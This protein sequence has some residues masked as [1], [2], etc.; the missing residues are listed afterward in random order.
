M[1]TTLKRVWKWN[2]CQDGWKK[3]L[4]SL[5]KTEP[6]DEPISIEHII[7][8][9]GIRDAIWALR[10]TEGHDREIRLYAVW[11]ERHLMED[12]RSI[13]AL[14]VA[15]RYA[16]GLATNQELAAA[17]AAA[18][19]DAAWAEA[20]DEAFAPAWDRAWAAARASA[21]D[22]ARG[23]AWGAQEKELRRV[24]QCINAGVD[25]YPYTPKQ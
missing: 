24:C 13:D 12:Q 20:W 23:A 25:P 10:A 15:E 16:N 18:W 22:T 17:W 6:D 8:S 3:L 21:S 4:E 14:D 11:C 9:N 19:G 5:N 2:P 7:D 1:K